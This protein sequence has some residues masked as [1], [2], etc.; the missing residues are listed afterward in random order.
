MIEKMT[1]KTETT[2]ICGIKKTI[3][4]VYRRTERDTD[5]R[6]DYIITLYELGDASAVVHDFFLGGNRYGRDSA[7]MTPFGKDMP[8]QRT[9]TYKHASS[10]HEKAVEWCIEHK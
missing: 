9:R 3:E 2:T 6:L 5:F 7:V 1:E 10:A 4:K 8:R